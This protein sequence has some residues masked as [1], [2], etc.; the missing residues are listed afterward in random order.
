MNECNGFEKQLPTP[1]LDPLLVGE[2]MGSDAFFVGD[3]VL[4][5]SEENKPT[6]VTSCHHDLIFVDQGMGENFEDSLV[7]F[8]P[9][10]LGYPLDHRFWS[11]HQKRCYLRCYV[12]PQ[13]LTRWNSQS[14][15]LLEKDGTKKLCFLG[16]LLSLIAL[17]AKVCDYIARAYSVS[18]LVW[19]IH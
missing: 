12:D 1:K 14:S 19:L 10:Q 7:H 8:Y 9:E 16:I 15:N 13:L 4:L 11:N 18:T 6:K 17:V 2:V 3:W 5:R